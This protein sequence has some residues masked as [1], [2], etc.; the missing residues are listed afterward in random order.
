MNERV[1]L[2]VFFSELIPAPFSDDVD[3]SNTKTTGVGR[4]TTD[5]D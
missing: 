3:S 2:V 4:E 1:P 5:D